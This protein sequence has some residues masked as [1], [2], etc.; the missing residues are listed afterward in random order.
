MSSVYIAVFL[1][2]CLGR[3]S[4]FYCGLGCDYEPNC[5]DEI[6]YCYSDET[7]LNDGVGGCQP[8]VTETLTLGYWGLV[9]T[10]E[11]LDTVTAYTDTIVD[12]VTTTRGSLKVEASIEAETIVCRSG[13]FNVRISGLADLTVFCSSEQ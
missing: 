11:Y 8:F 6:S 2:A 3:C 5:A 1:A 12:Y 7:C 9:W 13:I 4:A 10:T